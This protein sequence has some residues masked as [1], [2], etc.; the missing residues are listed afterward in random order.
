MSVL[1]ALTVEELADKLE[2]TDAPVLLDVRENNEFAVCSLPGA[3]HIPVGQIV[4][5]IG[6]LPKDK[7]IAVYCHHGGRSARIT[8]Y[9]LAQGYQAVNITG[10]IHAWASRVNPDMPTY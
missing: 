4:E 6:E 2:G 1:P 9:L 5:R 10:G 8:G 7:P 3:V